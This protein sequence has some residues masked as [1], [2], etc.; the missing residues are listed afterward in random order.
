LGSI[1]SDRVSHIKPSPTLAVTARAN[2]LKAQGVDIISL[3]AGEPDFDTPKHI[4]MAAIQAIQ[5]GLTK[6]TAVEGTLSLRRAIVK[7]FAQDNG[8]SYTP[9]EI[10]VSNGAKQS[11]FNLI[12]ALVNPGDEVI[13]P[14]PYWVSY[15]DMVLLGE[16]KPVILPTSIESHFKITAEQLDAAI[17]P[18]TRLLI[19]NSP[20]NPTGIAYSAQELKALV[21]VLQKHPKVW[22]AS[23]DIYE[24]I[25][26]SPDPFVNV[27]SIDPEL[28][29]RTV[30]I[31][32]VSKTYAMTGWRIGYA[33]GPADLIEMMTNIQS[34]STSNPCSI[35]Q[36][37][38]EAALEGDQRTIS[39]MVDAFKLRHDYIVEAL[40]RIEGISCLPADGTFYVFPNAER[41]IDK[42]PGVADDV[43]LAEYLIQHAKVALVPGSAFGAPGYLRLSFA[44][45]MPNLEE[46]IARLTQA[47]EQI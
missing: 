23:D 37:A 42:M 18:K 34:Q 36:A 46:S 16:G 19:L 7:K 14:A 28:R 45:S 31:H 11:I 1:F 2:A 27:L 40:N 20:S 10:L 8:V 25:R 21:A 24:H 17:T 15:P 30:I 35:S 47:F 38:A 33:A 13:I 22:I 9:S 44:T 5:K 29:S 43:A 4:K 26:W 6:Y 39:I 32:G 41:I 12:Q 3:G